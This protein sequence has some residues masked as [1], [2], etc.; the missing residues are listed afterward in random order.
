MVSLRGREFVRDQI[1]VGGG[2]T[3]QTSMDACIADLEPVRGAVQMA[4]R[5]SQLHGECELREK[6]SRL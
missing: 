2:E 5:Q 1:L 3:C 6:A 4:A